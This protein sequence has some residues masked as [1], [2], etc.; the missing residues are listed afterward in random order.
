MQNNLQ[1]IT[2]QIEEFFLEPNAMR[3]IVILMLALL[4]A[5]YV[6]KLIAHYLIKAARNIA[7]IADSSD[8]IEKSIRL[9][10]LETFLS[11]M[12]AVVRVL[13][14]VIVGYLTWR[15]LSPS[16][17]AT[18]AALG[19]SALIIVVAGATVGPLLRDVTAGTAMISER[20]YNVG[21]YIRVEPFMDV[22]GVVERVTLRSTKLR[23]LNGEVVWMHNQHMQA[24][25]VT[26]NGVRT[27][28][29]DVLCSDEALGKELVKKVIK[30]IP[31]GRMTV[32]NKLRITTTEQWDD[33]LWHIVVR[34]QTPPGREWLIEKYF[35]ESLIK[36]DEDYIKKKVLIHEPMVRFADP[37][38][39]KS[40]K[41]AVRIK[42]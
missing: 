39:E 2:Q 34:G 15:V 41:R 27:M 40:F 11:I 13:I 38:A 10:R 21:D 12:A 26:P 17:S 20:W 24:V 23:S 4:V 7:S 37:A 14:V 32:T 1:D 25:K 19:T 30:T 6:S 42:E 33:G 18:A 9:R 22:A 31:A 28:E 8:D 36:H 29:V 5:F 16:S 35:V 3:S